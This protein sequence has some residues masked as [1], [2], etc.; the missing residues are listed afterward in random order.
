MAKPMPW[1]K[2]WPSR[3]LGQK[4]GQ[5]DALAKKMAKHAPQF[6]RLATTAGWPSDKPARRGFP[7]KEVSAQPSRQRW[8][9]DVGN[10][11]ASRQPDDWRAAS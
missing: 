5:A 1:P 7:R 8:T 6:A 3:C 10:N 11:L 2:K 4:N 9:S